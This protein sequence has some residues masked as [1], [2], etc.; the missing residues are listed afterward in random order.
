MDDPADFQDLP[1]LPV[2]TLAEQRARQRHWLRYF[3]IPGDAGEWAELELGALDHG[4][5]ER[6]V[7]DAIDE[8]LESDDLE[9]PL[10]R[11]VDA[12]VARAVRRALRNS[13][14]TNGDG[15]D[16]AYSLI[17]DEQAPEFDDQAAARL[18]GIH[19]LLTFAD[20][21]APPDDGT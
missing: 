11:F 10:D 1:P 2:E 18:R 6:C 7:R 13:S 4:D 16:A 8:N 9:D 21:L 20:R 5:G 15:A 19:A 14:Y 12:R 17:R 3:P